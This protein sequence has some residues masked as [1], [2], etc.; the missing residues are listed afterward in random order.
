MSSPNDPGSWFVRGV[1]ERLRAT[2]FDGRRL[3]SRLAT[4]EA[5]GHPVASQQRRL[6]ELNRKIARIL[7]DELAGRGDS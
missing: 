5:I 7:T 4:L 2:E 1:K 3:A 6:L